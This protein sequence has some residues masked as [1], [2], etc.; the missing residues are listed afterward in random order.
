MV[1]QQ[2]K[3]DSLP[4]P[5]IQWISSSSSSWYLPIPS[6]LDFSVVHFEVHFANLQAFWPFEKP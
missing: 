5:T 2:Q 4:T 6:H 3:C 1:S